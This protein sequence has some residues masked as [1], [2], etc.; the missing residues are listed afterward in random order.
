MIR[1]IAVKLLFV[2]R[3]QKKKQNTKTQIGSTIFHTENIS[4]ASY[5]MQLALYS[6]WYGCNRN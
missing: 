2:F 4:F 6:T 5:R 3:K 1:E